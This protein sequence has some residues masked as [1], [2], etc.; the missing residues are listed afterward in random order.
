MAEAFW[1]VWNQAGKNPTHIHST[2]ESAKQEAE[3][4]ATRNPM[5]SFHV[6]QWV[7]TCQVKF[8]DW[9]FPDKDASD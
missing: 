4:L 2:Y 6:M 1:L 5:H 3:R 9:T 7:G 8:L